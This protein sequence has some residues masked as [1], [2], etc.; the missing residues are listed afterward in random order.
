MTAEIDAGIGW[1]RQTDHCQDRWE[2]VDHPDPSHSHDAAG[3]FTWR[4]ED[5]RDSDGAVV[6][7]KRVRLLSVITET[8]TVV[9]GQ[10]N[11]CVVGC[12]GLLQN[13]S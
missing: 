6:Y 1:N 13:L 12:T 3:N 7:E 9:R 5:Q 2:D 4:P 11:Q 8:L 10:N